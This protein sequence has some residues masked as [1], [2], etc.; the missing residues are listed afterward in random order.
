M[1]RIALTGGIASGKTTVAQLFTALGAR[2]IDTDQI[3]REVVAPGSPALRRITD[4]FGVSVLMPDG[5]LDR[6]RLRQIVFADA[7]AR[8]DLEAITHPEIRARVAELG[9]A[10]S[11]SP[12]G[13]YQLIAVP[14]LAES[15]T[16]RD[17]DRVLL[18]DIDPQLQL[19]R[20][21]VRDG[22]NE[23]DARQMIQA[24]ATREARLAIADDVIHNDGDIGRL[25][26]QVQALHERYIAI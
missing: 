12:G 3:A 20:L 15:G 22:L 13:P 4:R 6:A 2:L 25:A 10:M 18:V 9:A 19:H 11:A 14:L 21:M 17:Y 5:A 24:Q 1:L 26:Q 8:A 7:R 23:A 16:S